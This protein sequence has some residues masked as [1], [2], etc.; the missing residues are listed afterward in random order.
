M[1][2]LTQA[3]TRIALAQATMIQR[4][5]LIRLACRQEFPGLVEALELNPYLEMVSGK[6]GQ[7]L[8]KLLKPWVKYCPFVENGIMRFGE[9]LQRLDEAPH[10]ASTNWL[11]NR[12]NCEFLA[13]E[14]RT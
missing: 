10:R 11:F 5:A 8:R 7:D 14:E 1:L 12:T 9:R 2:T 13:S 6:R 3:A 4:F